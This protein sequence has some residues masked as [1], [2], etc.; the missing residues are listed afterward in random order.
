MNINPGAKKEDFSI[1][2]MDKRDIDC[3]LE[4]RNSDRVRLKMFEHHLIPRENHLKWFE[5][6]KGNQTSRCW[7]FSY[8]NEPIGVITIKIVDKQTD[9]WI[10]GCYL[11]PMRAVPKAGTIMGFI[12]H[13]HFFEVMKV[14]R[15]TGEAVAANTHSLEFNA[16]LGY[17]TEKLFTRTNTKGEPI[18]A[19]YLVMDREDWPEHKKRL[20]SFCFEN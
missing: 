13:E 6:L 16:R 12:A 1:R 8:K 20:V 11:G 5:S 10:W 15:V 3:V 7:I 14:A 9:T 18:P 2:P 17:R 4:W 19:V